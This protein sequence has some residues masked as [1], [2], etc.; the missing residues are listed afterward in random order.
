MQLSDPEFHNK[1]F[2]LLYDTLLKNDYPK[3]LIKNIIEK[4]LNGM[5]NN[6]ATNQEEKEQTKFVSIPYIKGLFEKIKHIFRDTD[7]KIVGSGGNNLNKNIFSRLKDKIPKDKQSHIVYKIPCC[8]ENSYVGETRNRL[9]TRTGQH[10]YNIESVT[11]LSVN[12]Q[13]MKNIHRN[14][15]KQKFFSKKE[16]TKRDKSRK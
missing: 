5:R 14:L 6:N 10:E 9:A 4:T 15:T 13:S 11:V 7:T 16:T 8:E 2:Q 1:N 3:K 12:T